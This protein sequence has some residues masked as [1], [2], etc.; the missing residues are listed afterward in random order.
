MTDDQLRGLD[1]VLVVVAHPDDAEFASG[2][3]IAMFADAGARVHV[4]VATNGASGTSDPSHTR[5][6]LAA[7]RREEQEKASS[8][9][10]AAEVIWLGYE[11]G[12]L[13]PSMELRRDIT[14]QIRRVRPQLLITS[15]PTRWYAFDRYI[16]HPDHRAVGEAALGAVIPSSDSRLVF[17]ELLEEGF[18]PHKVDAVWMANAVESDHILDVGATMERKIA[19]LLCH[20]SQVGPD[21][22]GFVRERNRAIASEQPFEYG[23]AYKA[24]WYR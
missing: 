22:E 18:E 6:S 23:E 8:V 2:G 12:Y 11:D 20:A 1:P 5:V 24:I 14:R 4:C 17:P 10:G 16:N 3:T 9:L 13:T 15:D 7:V 21:V 19:A